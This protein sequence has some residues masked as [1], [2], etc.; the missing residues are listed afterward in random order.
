VKFG[1]RHPSKAA[2]FKLED[3]VLDLRALP[4]PPSSTGYAVNATASLSQMYDNDTLGDCVIAGGYHLLGV[5]TGNAGPPFVAS[6][7]QIVAD[8]SAIGGYQPGLPDT[9][10]GCDETVA[11]DYWTTHGYADGSTLTGYVSVDATNP[12]I[13]RVASWL[14]EGLMLG[15]EL[16][17]AWSQSLPSASGFVWDVAGAPNPNSGHCVVAVDYNDT[18][19]VIVTWGLTGTITYA[20]LAEY[21]TRSSGGALYAMIAADTIPVGKTLAP[22]GLAWTQLEGVFRTLGG[23]LP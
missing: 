19:L 8:Y 7:A 1:R 16:P 15:I 22:S 21:A 10:Q 11:L 9:D 14:F 2:R 13:V 4:T 6:S 20:A 17:D 12:G 5:R 3:F 23:T 18:G